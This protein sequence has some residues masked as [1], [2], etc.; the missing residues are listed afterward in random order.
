MNLQQCTQVSCQKIATVRFSYNYF[1]SGMKMQRDSND[2]HALLAKL[3]RL[4]KLD[5]TD[6]FT[7]H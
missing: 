3:K 1:L 2:I 5:I 7:L 4:A 6:G